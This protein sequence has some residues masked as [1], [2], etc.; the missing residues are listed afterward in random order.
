MFKRVHS[1]GGVANVHDI[2][3]YYLRPQ[4]KPTDPLKLWRGR[5]IDVLL[6]LTNLSQPRYYVVQVLNP[7]FE[8]CEEVVFLSQVVGFEPPHI[9]P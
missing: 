4:E 8:D 5:I 9:E 2:L 6:S 3:S 7:G 1:T